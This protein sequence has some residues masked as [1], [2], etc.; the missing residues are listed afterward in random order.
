MLK[1]KHVIEHFAMTEQSVD[2]LLK[3]WH[4]LE[5]LQSVLHLP[6]LSTVMLQT[7]DY[8][9]SD[10][11][12]LLQM[13]EMKLNQIKSI[14]CRYTN[15]A[16]SLQSK[17][18]KRKKP[19]IENPLMRCAMYL[20]PRFKCDIDSHEE[21]VVFVKL[22][23][24]SVWQRIKAVKSYEETNGMISAAVEVQKKT[25]GRNQRFVC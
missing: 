17:L 22:T 15:L 21:L 25:I 24:E 20:D 11:Y 3:R 23:L 14:P 13:M 6:Y 16:D 2:L 5:E 4:I 10:F 8:T 7:K 12:G 18:N 1:C 19:L 9:L